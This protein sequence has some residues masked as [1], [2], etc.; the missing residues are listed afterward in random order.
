MTHAEAKHAPAPGASAPPP[1][2][3]NRS[4]GVVA[5]AAAALA[6]LFYRL[7]VTGPRPPAAGPLLVV[8]NHPNS[9]LDVALVTLATGRAARFLAK[10][11]LWHDPK[12]AWLVRASGALPVYRQQ[13]AAIT[14]GDPPGGAPRDTPPADRAAGNRAMF[15]AAEH[16]LAAGDAIALFPE[17][18]SHVRPALAPLK[19]GAARLA[20]GAARRTGG[21]FPLV[22][23]GITLDDRETFRSTG[24]LVVGAP[25]D[26]DDLAAR[27]LDPRGGDAD[28]LDPTLVRALTERID[29][30][31]HAVTA[32]YES[33]DDARLVATAERVHAAA[34]EAARLGLPGSGG[35]PPL[36]F[37]IDPPPPHFAPDA[38]TGRLER[39]HLGATLLGHA[40]T[41][42]GPAADAA[43][44]RL[45]ALAGALRAHERALGVLHLTPSDLAIPS[46]RA[47]AAGWAKRRL[48]L[49]FVAA[50][51]LAGTALGWIPYRLTG[52][53]AP[54]V[55]GTADRDVLATAKALV[56]ALCFALWLVVLAAVA[57]LLF[58]G[59]T[60]LAV[61]VL[62]P[63]LLVVALLGGERWL[64]AL[65]DVR[66]FFRLRR[67]PDRVAR[68]RARQAGLAREVE[69]VGALLRG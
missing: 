4:A 63:A 48:D 54:R 56:G 59:V 1:A 9:L 52:V 50:L 6:R 51:A 69:E 11:T 10:S 61:L 30:A 62:G 55:A 57:G 15:E 35:G 33:W 27:A 20:L 44:V 42:T 67:R 34:A 49:P 14:S 24:L 66:R 60:A 29:D 45:A 43:R 68:L 18:I 25:I 3:R 58:G 31:L 53:L 17:G 22:P 28:D 16:A 46:D 26:W 37:Q 8:A 39:Y 2:H 5:R 13:D 47:T 64:F 32:S 7:E 36:V 41:A 21:T 19:T 12:V 23:V 65:R 38:G 40:R